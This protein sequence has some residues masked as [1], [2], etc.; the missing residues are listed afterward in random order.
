MRMT[1]GVV[2]AAA[3]VAAFLLGRLSVPREKSESAVQPVPVGGAVGRHDQSV[4]VLQADG[5]RPSPQAEETA[6]G[7]HATIEETQESADADAA[8]EEADPGEQKEDPQ[9]P[10]HALRRALQGIEDQN[11]TQLLNAA[12]FLAREDLP[13]VD[14]Q[15]I[16]AARRNRITPW[17][18]D[19]NVVF[20]LWKTGRSEW[21]DMERLVLDGIAAGDGLSV[22]AWVVVA[23]RAAPPPD[24]DWF[25]WILGEHDLPKKVVALVKK[26]LADRKAGN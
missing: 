16:Q 9:D 25:G 20:Y 22:A 11:W 18:A 12:P 10:E 24:P 15:L 13:T 14:A 4:P 5:H 3:L 7:S 21:R 23:L 1:F 8:D 26:H 17:N 19:P 6:D 2:I